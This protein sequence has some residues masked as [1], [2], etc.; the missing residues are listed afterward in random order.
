MIHLG[1]EGA[2]PCRDLRCP[3][4]RM[5]AGGADGHGDAVDVVYA[6]DCQHGGRGRGAG[7]GRPAPGAAARPRISR[8][9]RQRA[10]QPASLTRR[11]G[12]RC[13]SP[14][15]RDARR[16]REGGGALHDALLAEANE[17][18]RRAR[19]RARPRLHLPAEGSLDEA[20][21]DEAGIQRL[22]SPAKDW[23]DATVDVTRLDEL[24]AARDARDARGP[25]RGAPAGQRRRRAGRHAERAALRSACP[26]TTR[27]RGLDARPPRHGER[28]RRRAR[29]AGSAGP[30]T[31]AAAGST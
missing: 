2:L 20:D 15:S 1:R 10:A 17:A 16:A 14:S 4:R 12:R 5:A 29:R 11:S 21:G 31:R 25:R 3:P 24:I 27:R 8:A 30:P 13:A 18:A 23:L 7:R 19:R 26:T 22:K 28:R 6:R 9:R